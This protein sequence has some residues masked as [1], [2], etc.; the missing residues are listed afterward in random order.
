[1]QVENAIRDKLKL[2]LA[3]ELLWLENES[4]RHSGPPGRE[5]HF[6]VT[7]VSSAFSGLSP[8]KRHQRVYTIL[9]EEKA[10]PVHALAMHLYTP[11]EWEKRG[12]ERPDSPNCR[13]GS[14]SS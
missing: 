6:K 3:P 8:V 2:A 11:D 7:L 14:V 4:D 13:G 10:G 5:S 12:G 9:A 1:M